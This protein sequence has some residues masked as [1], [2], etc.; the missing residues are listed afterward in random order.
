MQ[1][2]CIVNKSKENLNKNV[3]KNKSKKK[4]KIVFGMT[5]CMMILNLSFNIVL[6]TSNTEDFGRYHIYSY[7]NSYRYIKYRNLPQR[8]HEY[9]YLD[10]N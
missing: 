4:L 5:L 3:E 9:Y 7:E 8:I 1:K 10:N 2:I 6:A